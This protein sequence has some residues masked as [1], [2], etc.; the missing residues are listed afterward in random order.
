MD[1]R[2]AGRREEA[3][4]PVRNVSRG[5]RFV[6]GL[7]KNRKVDD[8]GR[9]SAR[10]RAPLATLYVAAPH[11]HPLQTAIPMKLVLRDR[12]FAIEEA[13]LAA[14]IPDPYWSRKNDPKGQA[15]LTWS[16]TVDAEEREIDDDW[17]QPRAYHEEMPARRWTDRRPFR[18]S[19]PTER[20]G[21]VGQGRTP[22]PALPS[23]ARVIH[24]ACVREHVRQGGDARGGCCAMWRNKDALLSG[25]R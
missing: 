18:R 20:G 11:L 22:L 15:G 17:R 9:G 12:V 19:G 25:I 7:E 4:A 6:Q 24:R 2:V 3:S 1:S 5:E 23:P 21:G 8:G 16:L 14:T 13:T 10:L